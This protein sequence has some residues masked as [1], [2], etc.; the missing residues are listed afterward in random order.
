M[1]DF[2]DE[3]GRRRSLE[4]GQDGGGGEVRLQRCGDGAE[5]EEGGWIG[6]EGD[7]GERSD[8]KQLRDVLLLLA[9]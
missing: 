5:G 6:G 3:V 4:H 9:G 7:A 1:D 2:G 8:G